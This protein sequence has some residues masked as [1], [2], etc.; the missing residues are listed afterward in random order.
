MSLFHPSIKKVVFSDV[1]EIIEIIDEAFPYITFTKEK[2]IK[3]L[4]SPN[5]LLLKSV[6]GNIFT[7]FLEVEFINTSK[8][9][10]NAVYVNDAFRCQGFATKLINEAIHEVKRKKVNYFFLLVKENNLVAKKLYE[11]VGFVFEKFHDKKLDGSV[12]EVWGYKK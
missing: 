4:S 9:R 8:A 11:K 10:L 2:V 3:K 12:V 1:D 6:R 7:G 5:F